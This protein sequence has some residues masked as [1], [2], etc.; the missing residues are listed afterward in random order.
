MKI[1]ITSKKYD[2]KTGVHV[3]RERGFAVEDIGKCLRC[4]MDGEENDYAGAVA[5]ASRALSVPRRKLK[6]AL[7]D[8][9][10]TML[11]G[12]EHKGEYA[13]EITGG[14]EGKG[15]DIDA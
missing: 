10:L 1:N 6:A 15:H 5:D 13:V 9:I 2:A 3:T 12:L 8:C 7:A 14:E 4:L 11:D